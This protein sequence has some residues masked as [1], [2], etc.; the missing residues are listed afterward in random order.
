MI[1]GHFENIFGL[2][3]FGSFLSIFYAYNATKGMKIATTAEQPNFK[4]FY[5]S[6]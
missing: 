2:W 3:I 4:G 5:R 1:I 6:K